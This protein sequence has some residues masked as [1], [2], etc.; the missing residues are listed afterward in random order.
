MADLWTLLYIA[1]NN[2]VFNDVCMEI[3]SLFLNLMNNAHH[4]DQKNVLL[5]N[6]KSL[7][8]TSL[9]FIIL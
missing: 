9:C 6:F 4:F 1:S 7:L 3:I 5:F 2:I 8:T